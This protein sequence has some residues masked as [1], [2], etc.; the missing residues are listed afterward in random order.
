MKIGIFSKDRNTSLEDYLKY[1]FP[2]TEEWTWNEAIPAKT[3]REL[4]SK[5]LPKTRQY[6]PDSFSKEL[7]LVVE[8]DGKPHY[9][10][11]LVII[12]DKEKDNYYKEL[13]LTVVRIPYWIQLSKENIGYPLKRVVKS[14]KNIV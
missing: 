7:K 3:Q 5:E 6:R 8:F 2:T 13:G 4:A 10:N 1:I 12:K 11:P 14:L 9:Q